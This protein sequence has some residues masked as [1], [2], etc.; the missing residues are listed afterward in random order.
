MDNSHLKELF[1]ILFRK[2]Q[3]VKDTGFEDLSGQEWEKL[4]DLAKKQN[5]IP[6]FFDSLCENDLG[7]LI[8][9]EQLRKLE[10]A[11][12][13]AVFR[14]LQVKAE[15]IKILRKLLERLVAQRRA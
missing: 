4:I 1:L 8:S 10:Q 2:S 11:K 13:R 7:H 14:N 3:T 12:N 5:I 15:L 6:L 9:P